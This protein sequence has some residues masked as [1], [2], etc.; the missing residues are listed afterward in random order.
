M[1]NDGTVNGNTVT[2][3]IAVTAVNDAP[4]ITSNGGGATASV[5]VAETSTAV[6]TV[7]ATDADAG[8]A[9]YS[10]VAAGDAAVS[11]STAARAR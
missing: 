9:D 7:T 10:L 3:D 4:V 1:A 5:S 6:T 11:R 8:T 2:R